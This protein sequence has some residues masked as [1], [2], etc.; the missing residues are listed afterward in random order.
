MRLNLTLP[1]RFDF[2]ADREL[3]GHDLLR[4]QA[5]DALRTQTSGD[6]ALPQS[7]AEWEREADARGEIRARA[8]ALDGW[9]GAGPSLASYGAGTALLELWLARIRPGRSIAVTDFTPAAVE[10]L[11]A[12]F[13]EAR[14]ECHDLLADAPLEAD[15][16]LFHRVD[17]EFTNDQWR[18]IL[19]RYA[20]CRML[21][22]PG[23][24]LDL[25]A[26]ARA[27]YRR[28][29]LRGGTHAGWLRTSAA[30]AALWETTHDAA[31]VRIHDLDGW[32]LEPRGS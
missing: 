2:G 29:R 9:L 18:S 27:L 5:W 13:P 11:R 24:V 25:R 22:V 28:A 8:K 3:V 20:S 32:A 16:H 7:R 19:A 26:A 14:V 1:H 4:V 23:D 21:V 31:P 12:L 10:R 15:L 30:F 17:T 6:F